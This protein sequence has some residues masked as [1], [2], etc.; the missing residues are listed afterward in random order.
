MQLLVRL[1]LMVQN[2]IFIKE[3]NAK[4]GVLGKQIQGVADADNKSEPAEVSKC[5]DEVVKPR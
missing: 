2:V 1:L 4:G 5:D 3:A